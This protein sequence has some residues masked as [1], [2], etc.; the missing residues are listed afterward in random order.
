MV[1]QKSCGVEHSSSALSNGHCWKCS[2]LPWAPLEA[3]L[4]VPASPSAGSGSS[5]GVSPGVCWRDAPFSI[6]KKGG[7]LIMNL[8]PSL[9]LPIAALGKGKY[10]M[11]RVSC[12]LRDVVPWLCFRSVR[13]LVYSWYC[14]EI[15][16]ITKL[17]KYRVPLQIPSNINLTSSTVRGRGATLPRETE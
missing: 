12:L 5:A 14:A 10:W 1:L 16:W 7:G 4:G 11:R 15:C 8:R 13:V 2:C 17:L 3:R 9:Y 6:G